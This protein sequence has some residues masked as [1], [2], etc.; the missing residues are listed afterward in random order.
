MAAPAKTKPGKASSTKK[1]PGKGSP[2]NRKKPGKAS[3]AKKAAGR[4]RHVVRPDVREK[5]LD[6]AEVVIREEGYAAA[7]VRRIATQAGL[8]HQAVFYYFGTHE[9]LLLAVYRRAADAHAEQLEMALNSDNPVRAMWNLNSDSTATGLGLEFMALAN[10][11]ETIRAEIARRSEAFRAREAEAL[12]RHLAERGIEPRLS[13]EMVSILTNAL[14]RLL[15]QEATLGIH[16]GHDEAIALVE[17]SLGS[18]ESRG[19]SDLDEMEAVVGA[20][21]GSR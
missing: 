20:I 19:Y 6:A 3:P 12:R 21:G 1:Q 5:L 11:N 4:R 18:F 17:A 13:P 2:A 9:D 8:K 15:V 10:H 16:S 14:A 7:T